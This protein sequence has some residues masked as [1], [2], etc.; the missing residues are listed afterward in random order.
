MDAQFLMISL[1][2]FLMPFYGFLQEMSR[3][4]NSSLQDW[5]ARFAQVSIHD[6]DGLMILKSQS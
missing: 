1:N 4:A 6:I 3:M 5:N 2:V